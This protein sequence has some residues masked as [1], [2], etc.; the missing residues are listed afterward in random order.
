MAC[1]ASQ[2]FIVHQSNYLPFIPASDLRPAGS[3]ENLSKGSFASS[4]LSS[5]TTPESLPPLP[6]LPGLPST[7][8]GMGLL[9]NQLAMAPSLFPVAGAMLPGMLDIRPPPLGRM[10]PG[11]RDRNRSYTSRSPSPDSSSYRGSRRHHARDGSPGSRSERRHS[12]VHRGPS[13]TRSDRGYR[14][15]QDRQYSYDRH[16][17]DSSPDR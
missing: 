15:Y 3:V 4:G 12:P 10:S 14:D 5:P 13:P 2:L 6:G 9:P 8:P 17:R 16:Y 11:P 1:F 7:M